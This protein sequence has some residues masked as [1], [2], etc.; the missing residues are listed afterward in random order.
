MP[1]ISIFIS[2]HLYS[3]VYSHIFYYYYHDCHIMSYHC[4]Y[5][6]WCQDAGTD[7]AANLVRNDNEIL[8]PLGSWCHSVLNIAMEDGPLVDD[9]PMKRGDFQWLCQFTRG[10]ID[11]IETYSESDQA[12]QKILHPSCLLCTIASSVRQHTV[13]LSVGCAT[14]LQNSKIR[15]HQSSQ[16]VAQADIDRSMIWRQGLWI[17]TLVACEHQYSK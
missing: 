12:F 11:F 4:K 17:K 10:Y 5:S 15:S 3:Y 7:T 8:G 6:N 9:L 1:W 13:K 2:I 16:A 14:I